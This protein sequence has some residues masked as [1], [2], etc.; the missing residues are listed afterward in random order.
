MDFGF[1]EEQEI[2]R[3]SAK[4]FLTD[5]CS[6]KFVRQMMA[7]ATAHD[8]GF[9][10][11][12]VELGWPGLLIPADYGG[13]GGTFLDMTVIA[14]EAGKALIPG[15][16]FATALLGAPA[17]I[18]GGS[19]AQKK[20]LLPKIAEGKYIATVALAESSGRFD[21]GGVELKAVKKGADYV[22]SGE[23]FFV[24][25]AHVA[26]CIVVAARTGASGENGVTLL[27]VPAK[28]KG[29]TITQLKTV[30]MTRRLCHIKFDNVTVSGANLLGKEGSG[31][32]TMRR[33]LDI[34][35]AALAA[36]MV[37][38]AQKALDIA[39]DYAK[40]R[41]QFGKPIGS[42]QAVKHKCVDMMVSVE[43]ARSLTYYACWTVDEKLAEAATA[44]P[45]AKAYASDM[46]KNV[47][48]EAIQVH[49]GIGFTWEHDMHLYHRRALAG[50][51]NF[52]NAPIH[53][54]TVAKSLLA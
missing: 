41:V 12:I 51:A 45:M 27:M 1:S 14:E 24:P 20:E 3:D 26:D 6:T 35:T 34:A 54:E 5:N 46:A 53:R 50:E 38:T 25:D 43:N 42:F 7:D 39:V 4:R 37:G 21:A 32:P 31:W 47:T 18:E 16:F 30:D 49:G 15:P 40:T 36:E 8:A 22:I 28:D 33:T 19:E 2:L 9:W 48:S 13:T 44:V 17:I 11:K 10:S 29:V 23:K 52:G